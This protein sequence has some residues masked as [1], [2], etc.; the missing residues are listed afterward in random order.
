[1]VYSTIL[2][3]KTLYKDQS[4]KEKEGKDEKK[5]KKKKHSLLIKFLFKSCMHYKKCLNLNIMMDI[6][7]YFS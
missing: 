7:K 5:T 1:M 4:P 3:L 2:D 6:Q